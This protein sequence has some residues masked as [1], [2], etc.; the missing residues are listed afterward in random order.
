MQLTC[1]Q[2]MGH[3]YPWDLLSEP[4]NQGPQGTDF[5]PGLSSHDQE[6]AKAFHHF[7]NLP[8]HLAGAETMSMMGRTTT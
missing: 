5:S 2:G 1:L 8:D 6:N 7:D 4:M 3:L